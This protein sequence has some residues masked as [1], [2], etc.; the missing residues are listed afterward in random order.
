VAPVEVLDFDSLSS[1]RPLLRDCNSNK[2]AS[3]AVDFDQCDASDRQRPLSPLERSVLH[4][5]PSCETRRP[6]ATAHSTAIGRIEPMIESPGL[7]ERIFRHAAMLTN[8]QRVYRAVRLAESND[9]GDD[10]SESNHVAFL[11]VS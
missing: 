11:L 7:G 4:A 1:A 2:S 6:N 10:V 3:R 9:G 5:A 8:R